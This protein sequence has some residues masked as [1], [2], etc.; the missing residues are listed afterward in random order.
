MIEADSEFFS[1][2]GD[3]KCKS[4]FHVVPA[5]CSDLLD[6]AQQ[7]FCDHGKLEEILTW[8]VRRAN[9]ASTQFA[10]GYTL[11]PISHRHAHIVTRGTLEGGAVVP[12][13]AW[14]HE[15]DG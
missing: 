15:L 8:N 9:Y 13:F 2:T 12:V 14:M 11:C 7:L 1:S 6:L 4:E 10:A 5:R 3:T